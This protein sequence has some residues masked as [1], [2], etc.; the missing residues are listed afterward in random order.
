MIQIQMTNIVYNCISN[1][2]TTYMA[3]V[4]KW[5]IFIVVLIC[6]SKYHNSIKSQKMN[7]IL[8]QN[9]ENIP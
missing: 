8:S 2:R 4:Y 6:L 7:V 9:N 5:L 1:E 3:F